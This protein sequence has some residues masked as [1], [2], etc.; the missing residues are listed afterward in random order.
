MRK[1]A[2]HIG[3]S[4]FS[5]KHWK[6]IFYP[7]DLKTNEWLLFYTERFKIT[8]INASFYHLPNI[9]TT[10]AWAEKVPK[11]FMFCPKMSRYLTHM[12]KLN[13]PEKSF[14]KFF[15]VFAPLKKKLGPVL[16][17]LPPSLH[18]NYEKT[19]HLYKLCKKEYSYYSF[20]MEVRHPTWLSKE[21]ID[22]M[23]QYNIAFVISQSGVGFPYEE[24]AT[25]NHV[26]VRFHGP[27]QLY[28]S[29]YSDEHLTHYANLF[30]QWFNEGRSVYAFFNNDVFG[31]AFNDAKRLENMIARL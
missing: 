21:S 18:F 24:I 11:D 16:I 31:Y 29:Q 13:D 10:E 6:G 15:D 28:A 20:A 12:K 27:A 1:P 17:Q 3:T 4:G 19:E 2:I 22:L 26:Y 9:K 30:K 14:E 23:K 5:Y 8:E 7:E 25:A